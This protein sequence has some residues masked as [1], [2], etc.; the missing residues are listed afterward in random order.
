MEGIFFR[1]F[2]MIIPALQAKLQMVINNCVNTSHEHTTNACC[3]VLAP[4]IANT[5]ALPDANGLLAT[6]NI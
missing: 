5:T 1:N 4:S 6:K 3:N 2:Q